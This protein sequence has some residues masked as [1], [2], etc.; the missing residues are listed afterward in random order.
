MVTVSGEPA[1]KDIVAAFSL[2]APTA[3]LLNLYGSTE[4]QQEKAHPAFYSNS[5]SFRTHNIQTRIHAC[6]RALQVTGDV[7]FSTLWPGGC[8]DLAAERDTILASFPELGS[9]IG[10]PIPG[11]TCRVVIREL[12]DRLRLRLA[13]DGEVGELLVSGEHVSLG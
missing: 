5:S 6:A 4:V 11:N 1:T 12:D 9:P 3:R 8:T 2:A 13:G 7:T 10:E